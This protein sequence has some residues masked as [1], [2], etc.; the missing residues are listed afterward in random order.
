MSH[1]QHTFCVRGQAVD[2]SVSHVFSVTTAHRP[3]TTHRKGS[4]AGLQKNWMLNLE[5][6]DFHVASR[7]FLLLIIF[8]PLENVKSILSLWVI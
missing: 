6:H 3:Q 8:Q 4:V 7:V 2:A 5:C 1:S